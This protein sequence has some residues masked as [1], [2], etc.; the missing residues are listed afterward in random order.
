MNISSQNPSLSQGDK[1]RYEALK[2]S[3]ATWRRDSVFS[4]DI[5]V[6]LEA[7]TTGGSS[8]AAGAPAASAPAPRP[9]SHSSHG[10]HKQHG[11]SGGLGSPGAVSSGGVI[12]AAGGGG[13]SGSGGGG[14]GSGRVGSG[15]AVTTGGVAVSA[16]YGVAPPHGAL[17][18][19]KR[20]GCVPLC[21]GVCRCVPVCAG[22]SRCVPLCAAVRRCVPLSAAVWW[23]WELRACGVRV[24]AV[25]V[26]CIDLC[27]CSLFSPHCFHDRAC[28]TSASTRC[29]RRGHGGSASTTR[30]QCTRWTWT[31][32]SFYWGRAGK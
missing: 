12:A 22:V 23:A 3:I 32:S 18:G 1:A 24:C 15:A 31:C 25:H 9:T 30:N 8:A 5:L 7:A 10:T 26:C 2:K 28:V 16:P 13:G 14:S 19:E 21:A 6:G 11:G 17:R 20:V 27:V 29:P 4:E